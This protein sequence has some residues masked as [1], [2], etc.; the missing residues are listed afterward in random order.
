MSIRKRPDGAYFI[1]YYESGRRGSPMR[2]E[3]LGRI[4][5]VE[6]VRIYKERVAL[7]AARRGAEDDSRV[8]L[9]MLAREYVNLHCTRKSDSARA[10]T[11]QALKVILPV[12]GE[13]IV[14][15]LKPLD[16]EAFRQKRLGDGVK[17]VTVNREWAILKAILNFGEKKGFISRNPIRRGSV[18]MFEAES[19]R[20]VFFEVG[21]WE[22]F[23]AAFDDEAAWKS[24]RTNLRKLGPVKE[25]L[26]GVRRYG[27]GMNPDSDATAEYRKRLR[28]AVPFFKTMLYTG[29]RPSEVLRLA[30][31]DIDFER[32]R[33]L[34]WQEKTKAAKPVPMSKAL[35]SVLSSLPRGI[36]AASVFARPDG[37]PLTIPEVTRAF[38]VAQKLSG[39]RAELSPYSIRHTFASWLAIKGTPIRTIQELLGH[40]DLRMT[41]RYAHL[42]P[43]HLAEAVET[44][45]AVEKSNRLRVG[46]ASADMGEA[47]TEAKPFDSSGSP[48][49]NRT[50]ISA[51]RGLRPDR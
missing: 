10:R 24:Y 47:K 40:R 42:S 20:E 45:E 9:A 7:A 39:V 29:S 21:E 5:Y 22:L 26:Q 30:W 34:I 37:K 36:G 38:R 11:E 46:C 32:G 15:T 6:A 25:G 31:Q 16:V 27:G 49:G 35:R 3:T 14:R 51:L 4:P 8:T 48:Y 12:L 1:R 13:R 43:A 28:A 18:A 19:R 41:L 44:V 23:I 2:Q 50:R 17:P 33:V